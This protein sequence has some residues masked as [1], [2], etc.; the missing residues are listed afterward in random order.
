MSKMS[1][2]TPVGP[3]SVEAKNGKIVRV[4]WRKTET[5]GEVDSVLTEAIGQLEAYFR[6]DLAE[7]DLPLAPDGSPFQQRV[8]DAMRRIPHGETWTYGELAVRA[9]T[10]ARAVGGACGA[11]PIPIIIPCHRVVAANGGAGGY[12][13]RGGLKTKS[14]LL[15]IENRTARLL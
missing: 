3:V 7:F 8:W 10:S 2:S 12:S 1:L 6:G 9:Q 14:A 11:N 4:G 13:G 15:D 5:T